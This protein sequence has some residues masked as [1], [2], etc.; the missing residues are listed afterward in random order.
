MISMLRTSHA[1]QSL[2]L[3]LTPMPTRAQRRWHGPLLHWSSEA[4]TRW[5]SNHLLGHGNGAEQRRMSS[6]WPG[7]TPR[8]LPPTE[9]AHA[10]FRT[11]TGPSAAR[12]RAASAAL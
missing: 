5:P 3:S 8:N 11:V 4:I 6:S 9:S 7:A 1:R 12:Q 2:L 10:K